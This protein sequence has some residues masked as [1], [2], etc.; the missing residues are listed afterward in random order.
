MNHV[1]S[2]DDLLQAHERIK[3]FVHQ[4]SVMT[5]ASIDAIAGCQIFFKCEN[6]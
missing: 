3:S 1:P 2:K 6:F 5:S 4:T